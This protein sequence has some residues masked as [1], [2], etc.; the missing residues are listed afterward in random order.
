M[1][2]IQQK[3]DVYVTRRGRAVRPPVRYEPEEVCE[4][5]YSDGEYESDSD[6]SE[7][8]TI[9]S[10]G[11]EEEEF[12]DSDEDEAGNLKGFVVDSDSESED[13]IS[14]SEE[15]EEEYCD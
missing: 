9:A 2:N 8:S 5:D 4:D 6:A 1:A 7:C 10:D 12:T 11:E 15:E 14:E 3:V 13:E